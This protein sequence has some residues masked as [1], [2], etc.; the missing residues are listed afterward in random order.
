M[1]GRCIDRE[2]HLIPWVVPGILDRRLGELKRGVE[3]CHLRRQ[4]A[5]IA[6]RRRLALAGEQISERPVH[7]HCDVECAGDGLR[8]P[9]DEHQLLNVKSAP[10]VRATLEDGKHRHR[11][12][13]SA[14][15]SEVPPQLNARVGS[16]R[17][18]A[19][20]GHAEQRVSAESMPVERPIETD[21][22][23]VDRLLVDRVGSPH[24]AGNLLPDHVY[25]MP[26]SAAAVAPVVVAGFQRLPTADRSARRNRGASAST[27]AQTNLHL[28]RR[29]SS[30]VEHL[31]G[32][33][34]RNRGIRSWF[35][36]AHGGH[37]AHGAPPAAARGA[38]SR[39]SSGST[40]STPRLTMP[41]RR[42]AALTR[43]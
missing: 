35:P 6:D 41:S 38:C 31:A 18:R 27:G 2:H 36:A 43:R 30:T 32:E 4:A 14:I 20:Q 19:R 28:Q 15:P 9:R 25:G 5:R 21:Q 26:H 33:N 17:M 34:V 13:V 23:A 37:G 29:R 3:G 10:R 42:L 22:K 8:L 7:P 1:G 16:G 11:Q 24:R 12:Y 40:H 39:S